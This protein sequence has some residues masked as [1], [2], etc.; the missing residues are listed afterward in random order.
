[1][2]ASKRRREALPP[3][4]SIFTTSAP[5]PAGIIRP[6]SAR[7]SVRYVPPPVT[8]AVVLVVE[9]PYGAPSAPVSVGTVA[10]RSVTPTMSRAAAPSS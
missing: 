1:M 2:R 9:T 3:G 5:K 10:G 6:S 4:G 8:M 7:E